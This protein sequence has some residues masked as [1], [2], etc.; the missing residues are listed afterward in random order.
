MPGD[1]P[2]YF[3]DRWKYQIPSS[4]YQVVSTK[5]QVLKEDSTSSPSLSSL[6]RSFSLS[7][8]F[9][10][11]SPVRWILAV[12]SS[13]AAF[14]CSG[15]SFWARLNA[16]CRNFWTYTPLHFTGVSAALYMFDS[17][18]WFDLS[19]LSLPLLSNA[20]CTCPTMLQDSP[21]VP[22]NWQLLRV[23]GALI[24]HLPPL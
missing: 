9:G 11:F 17:R 7:S 6:S 24:K 14:G 21:I 16:E 13:F 22:R 23:V 8:S 12:T 5:Y 1:P 20:Q 3:F 4:K 18:E 2:E 19:S 15:R 10:S